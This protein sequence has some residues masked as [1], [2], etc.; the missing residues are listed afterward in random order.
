MQSSDSLG[1][2]AKG[3]YV[4]VQVSVSS[5]NR[6]AVA[7]R[8]DVGM[9]KAQCLKVSISFAIDGDHSVLIRSC[10]YHMPSSHVSHDHNGGIDAALQAWQCL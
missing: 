5:L 7:T 4:S 3:Y 6:H 2:A 9:S 10:W 1:W 8:E